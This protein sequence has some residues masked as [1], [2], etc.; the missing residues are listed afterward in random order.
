M[1]EIYLEKEKLKDFII[2]LEY[3]KHGG[4]GII[5]KLTDDVLVKL[6]YYNY[7]FIASTPMYGLNTSGTTTEPSA[8]W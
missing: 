1:K 4:N 7:F 8:C 3:L 6:F 2:K 5:Y